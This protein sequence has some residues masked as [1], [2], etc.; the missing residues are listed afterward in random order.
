VTRAKWSVTRE[1][2]GRRQSV[3]RRVRACDRSP[4]L[5]GSYRRGVLLRALVARATS[6]HRKPRTSAGGSSAMGFARVVVVA[7]IYIF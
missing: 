2:V 3:S 5:T 1:V 4:R 7:A 6:G